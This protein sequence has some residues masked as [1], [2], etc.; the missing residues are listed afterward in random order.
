VGED[1]LGGV[2]LFNAGNDLHSA[3]RR[4]PPLGHTAAQ[5]LFELIAY[6]L[7]YGAILLREPFEEVRVMR[8]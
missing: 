3:M 8:L 5:I 4:A 2:W 6:V 7:R 1:G